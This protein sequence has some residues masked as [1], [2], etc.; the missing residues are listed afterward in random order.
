MYFGKDIALWKFS[1]CF[2]QFFILCGNENI[3]YKTVTL[4]TPN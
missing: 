2:L 1:S 3:V 4:K